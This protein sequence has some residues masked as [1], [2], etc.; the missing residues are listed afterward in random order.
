[1]DSSDEVVNA[2]YQ[3]VEVDDN[4]LKE[5][6]SLKKIYCLNLD[7]LLISI[8]PISKTK[9]RLMI[10]LHF[11]CFLA[12]TNSALKFSI[13]KISKAVIRGCWLKFKHL[14]YVKVG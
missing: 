3:G 7:I 9:I 4:K 5:M 11:H 14:L 10:L 6:K 2:M 1:M 12:L 13:M 8:N